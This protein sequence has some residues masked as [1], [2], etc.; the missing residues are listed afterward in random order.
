M[1][2]GLDFFFYI[3]NSIWHGIMH[4]GGDKKVELT[5]K[6]EGDN[7]R[8]EVID[9]GIGIDSSINQ[10]HKQ[11]NRRKFFGTQA[12]ENRIKLLH[13]QSNVIVDISD[14]SEGDITGTKVTLVFPIVRK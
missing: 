9:N 14:I 5:I 4:V 8:C 6:R 3:E 1:V 2:I 7:V 12:T 11:I 13:R 10:P